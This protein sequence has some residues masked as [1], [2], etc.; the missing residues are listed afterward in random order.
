VPVEPDPVLRLLWRH[1]VPAEER[2]PR[3][4]PRQRLSL[5]Q[6]VDT[7]IELADEQG[8]EAV[9]MRGLAKRL[10]I[11][12]MSLYTYVTN[13]S[14]LVVLMVDQVIGR[15][16]LP[17]MSGSL[18]ERL[19]L[20]ADVQLADHRE[21]AW[22]LDVAG[23]R[24]WLGPHVSDRYEWQLSAVEGIGLDDVEMDQTVTLVIGFATHVAQA[25]HAVRQAERESG[26][27]DLEWWDANADALGEVTAHRQ[28]PIASRVGQAAGEAYQAG[29]DPAR[30]LEFGLARILDGIEAYVRTR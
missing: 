18:R 12:A 3:R 17:P 23:V 16:S 4:G 5:D 21:H 24:P 28:Y 19:R 6:V 27:T 29:S 8:L 2:T 20:V 22:L 9:S 26:L 25:E 11:G 30:E 10:G 7:A 14:D 1:V 15:R 13:R